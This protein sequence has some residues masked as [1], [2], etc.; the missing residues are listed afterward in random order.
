VGPAVRLLRAGDHVISLVRFHGSTERRPTMAIDRKEGEGKM[1]EVKGQV[2]EGVGRLTG[3]RDLESQGRAEQIKGKIEKG[4]G[5]LRK[6]TK[7]VLDRAKEK[8]GEAKDKLDDP[9]R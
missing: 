6:G 1:D 2:K 5:N 8:L 4:L 3:D 9:N 7:D